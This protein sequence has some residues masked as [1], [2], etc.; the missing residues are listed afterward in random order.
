[1]GG[2]EL[3]EDLPHSSFGDYSKEQQI[4]FTCEYI[5]NILPQIVSMGEYSHSV[6]KYLL[7]YGQIMKVSLVQLGDLSFADFVKLQLSK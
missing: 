2:V 7:H 1:M 4:E 6:K 5:V 3:R